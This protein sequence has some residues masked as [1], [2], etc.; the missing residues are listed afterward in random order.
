M[1][2][3]NLHVFKEVK[4]AQRTGKQ[5]MTFIG[6]FITSGC[7]PGSS[8]PPHDLAFERYKILDALV[9]SVQG[10]TIDL[11]AVLRTIG[12]VIGQV[13]VKALANHEGTMKRV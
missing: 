3:C 12:T 6:R 11:H 9:S 2:C 8:Y 7:T 1:T 5:I 10:P 4:R 13:T